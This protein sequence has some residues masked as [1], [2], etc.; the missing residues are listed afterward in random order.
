MVATVEP[1]VEID[2]RIRANPA[3]LEAVTSALAYLGRHVRRVPLPAAIR[4]RFLPLD[5]GSL[6]LLMSDTAD[7][8]DAVARRV[9]PLAEMG[10][11]YV[12]EIGTLRAWRELLR[13]RS[14]QNMARIDARI[15]RIDFDAIQRAAEQFEGVTTGEPNELS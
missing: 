3:L 9:F 6:E 10:D 13:C 5:P 2:D 1:R 11:D 4:W 7:F 14:E 15:G 12:R 8:S